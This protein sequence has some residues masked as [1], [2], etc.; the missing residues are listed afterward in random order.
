MLSQRAACSVQGARCNSPHKCR[1]ADNRIVKMSKND[2]NDNNDDNNRKKKDEIHR[3][4][5]HT[6]ASLQYINEKCRNLK[7]M[8]SK[9]YSLTN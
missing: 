7:E 9:S 8:K 2:Y 3:G 4:K 5:S 6:D 1:S